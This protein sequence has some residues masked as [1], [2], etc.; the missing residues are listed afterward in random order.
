MTLEHAVASED[1]LLPAGASGTI[2]HVY[3]GASAYEVEFTDPFHT[4]TTV[5]AEYI[6][7]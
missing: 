2:V 5:R 4:V 7:A 6:V 3:P 1:G